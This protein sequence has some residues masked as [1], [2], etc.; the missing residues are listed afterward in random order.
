MIRSKA[1]LQVLPSTDALEKH[2]ST[3][4]RPDPFFVVGW[5]WLCE[6]SYTYMSST[7][8]TYPKFLGMSFNLG[9]ASTCPIVPTILRMLEKSRGAPS[10]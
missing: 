4:G 3:V 7:A 9:T 6:T 10:E 5:V 8:T 1:Q 2:Y